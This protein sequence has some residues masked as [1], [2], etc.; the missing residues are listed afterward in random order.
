MLA[1]CELAGLDSG[2]A[3]SPSAT[4]RTTTSCLAGAA[5]A[6]APAD[7]SDDVLHVAD[8]V[9]RLTRDGGWAEILQLV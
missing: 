6:V 5:V 4:V 2:S 3:C 7:A 8:H 1:Y 9:G